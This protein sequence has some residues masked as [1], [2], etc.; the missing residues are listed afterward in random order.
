ML[1][2]D[3]RGKYV[4]ILFYTA[5]MYHIANIM[6]AKGF[7]MPRH[8]TFSGNGSK[9]LSILSTNLA[10]LERFTKVIFEKIYNEYYKEK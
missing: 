5:M 6:K 3:N 1:A 8:I 7:S 10:T 4:I 9:V 2:D